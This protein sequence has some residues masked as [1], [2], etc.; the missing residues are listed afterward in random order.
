MDVGIVNNEST[1]TYTVKTSKKIPPP[2]SP[3]PTLVPVSTISPTF[4]GVLL[5]PIATLFSSQSIK[6]SQHE[7]KAD[8]DDDDFM[9]SFADFNSTLKKKIFLMN[10][11]CPLRSSRSSNQ[12]LILFFKSQQI[13]EEKKICDWIQ[14]GIFVESSRLSF[15]KLD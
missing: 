2:S 3:T 5:E 9:V 1:V 13:L 6:K 4:F 14:N 15:A 7:N 12:K 10:A 11:S 8:K